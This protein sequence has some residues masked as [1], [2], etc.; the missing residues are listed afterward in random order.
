M[1]GEIFE[2]G[3]QGFTQNFDANLQGIMI[4]PGGAFFGKMIVQL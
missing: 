3:D 1:F 2:H 4:W